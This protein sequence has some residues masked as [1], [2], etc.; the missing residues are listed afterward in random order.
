MHARDGRGLLEGER[1]ME[2]E[3]DQTDAHNQGVVGEPAPGDGH[4]LAAQIE[5]MQD[6]SRQQ[7]GQKDEREA[8]QALKNGGKAGE[9]VE[10]ID[11]NR[12]EPQGCQG[13]N[14]RLQQHPRPRVTKLAPQVEELDETD[15]Q[16]KRK[17]KNKAYV[18]C[19]LKK[20]NDPK[21]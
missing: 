11:E 14:D 7:A 9:G 15:N 20:T 21:W 13:I 16:P 1:L 3:T 4:M 19:I 2:E 10:L 5:E 6:R 8:A 17:N 12:R 18:G